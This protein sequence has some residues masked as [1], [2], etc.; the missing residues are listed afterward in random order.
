MTR[1]TLF[2]K[3]IGL[4]LIV[5]LLISCQPKTDFQNETAAGNLYTYRN[6]ETRWSSFENISAGKGMGGMENKG[7]KGHPCE[8]LSAG[9]SIVLLFTE[10]PGIITRMWFYH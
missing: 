5:R 1:P 2:F 7:A 6:V 4:I 3:L 10:G 9:E 8:Q